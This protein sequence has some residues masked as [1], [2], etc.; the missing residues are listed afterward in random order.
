MNS[1]LQRAAS[2]PMIW[3]STE[4]A[5]LL[6]LTYANCLGMCWKLIAKHSMEILK[7]ED[8]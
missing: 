8:N 6:L 4:F 7:L 3:Q 5:I 1:V 2:S